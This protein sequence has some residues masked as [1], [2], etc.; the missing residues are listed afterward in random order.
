MGASCFWAQKNKRMILPCLYNFI[1]S[2]SAF[3]RSR[4]CKTFAIFLIPRDKSFY[5]AVNF[6]WNT[7]NNRDIGFF[8]FA[9]LKLLRKKSM[10]LII[11]SGDYYS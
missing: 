10:S 2:Y 8:Y 11:I 4:N 9:G 7:A 5:T 1:K 3:P 6:F